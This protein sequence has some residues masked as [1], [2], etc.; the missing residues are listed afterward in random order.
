MGLYSTVLD[1]VT[2]TIYKTSSD[3]F[4]SLEQSYL[5]K[6]ILKSS[7]EKMIKKQDIILSN[8]LNQLSNQKK[9]LNSMNNKIQTLNRKN[10][11]K[12]M[13]IN[14]KKNIKKI[15]SIIFLLFCILVLILLLRKIILK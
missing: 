15:L 9:K 5:D 3:I 11:Y 1:N 2:N 12:Y 6:I 10:Y 13:D 7:R 8:K 14:N 4:N